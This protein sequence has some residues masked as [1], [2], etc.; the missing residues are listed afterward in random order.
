MQTHTH[1]RARTHTHART[2]I[3]TP[4]RH[5]GQQIIVVDYTDQRVGR[6]E[7]D[8]GEDGVEKDDA[9]NDENLDELRAPPQQLVEVAVTVP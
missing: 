9:G 2:H 8:H 4:N 5:H 3:S 6:D 1:T 7:I